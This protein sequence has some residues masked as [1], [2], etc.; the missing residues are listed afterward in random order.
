MSVVRWAASDELRSNSVD[1]I[2]TE[3]CTEDI[4]S[5]NLTKSG[6]FSGLMKSFSNKNGT[7]CSKIRLL[8]DSGGSTKVCRD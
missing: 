6:T 8:C 2:D 1:G 5:R 3:R 4:G 7:G